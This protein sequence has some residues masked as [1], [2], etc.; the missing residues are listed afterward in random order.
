MAILAVMEWHLPA[1]TRLFSAGFLGVDIFFVLSGFLITSLLV[2]E[3]A[4]TGSVSLRDFYERRA[5]RIL[6]PLFAAA[7]LAVV[8]VP[9]A[10][11]APWAAIT[12]LGNVP[13]LGSM[14]SLRHTWSLAVEE[15]FYIAWPLLFI[16]LRPRARTAAL[17]AAVVVAFTLRMYARD[18]FHLSYCATP[19]RMDSI[20][21]GCLCAL[22]FDRFRVK[23]W[24]AY[25]CMIGVALFVI[26]GKMDFMRG[27]GFTILALLT[28]VSIAAIVA[29]SPINAVLRSSTMQ[30]LGT[31][32]YG[33]YL[34][35]T[36]LFMFM[37]ASGM[38]PWQI[39]IA[40]FLVAE[41]SY[42][43]IEAWTRS[44][45]LG[46]ESPVRKGRGSSIA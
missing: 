17:V 16:F 2:A 1:A 45:R 12:L 44:P 3:Q 38:P 25:A 37:S 36:P 35:Q 9:P 8:L 30:Y 31:R 21:I 19:A 22:H 40:T 23:A 29:G 5:R 4:R 34:Y 33:L 32:S 46:A 42:R 41:L 13:D 14:G 15:H 28:A 26:Y 24:L 6:P 11:I 43:T 7:L 27:P 18:D 20:A 39:L 10:P